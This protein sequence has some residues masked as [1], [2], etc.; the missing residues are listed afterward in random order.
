[1]FSEPL[2]V[3]RPNLGDRE[4][5]HELV[6]S[7]WDRRWLTAGPLGE[8]FEERLAAVTGTRYCVAVCNAT[9]GMQIAVR[10][11]GVGPGDEVIVPSFTWVATA[12]ALSWIGVVPVFCDIDPD[13]ANADPAHVAQLITPRTRAILPVHVFGRPCDVDGLA[14][15]ADRHGIPVVYDAAH[16]LGSTIG[17]R[18][19]GGFGAAE[20]LS[21]H[22]TKFVNSFEGGAIVTNDEALA[23]TARAMRNFGIGEDRE[24]GSVGTNGKL[25]EGAAAMGL[26]SLEVMESIIDA[27]RTNYEQYDKELD[28]VSA[29]RL[30]PGTTGDERSN[31]QYVVVEIDERVSGVDRDD[32]HD[33]LL[34]ENV[35]SR[36]Y[37]HPCCH[38][39]E[40]YRRAPEV[41]APLPLPHSEALSRRVLAL[42][43]GTAIGAAEI[44]GICQIIR[45]TVQ[46]R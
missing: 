37:F 32:V 7:A 26:A 4:R 38:E 34:R 11:L 23:R 3:G 17:G 16:G 35:L 44:S 9:V 1:M 30:R 31:L 21:F 22:A 18:P 14:A 13:T 12:H 33:A 36:R 42:P 8:E 19:L 6:D 46:A 39:T 29:V 24:V 40:P 28:G 43:T 45:R 20:V 27:N 2:H 5:F 10:A 41:H 25:N 15:V